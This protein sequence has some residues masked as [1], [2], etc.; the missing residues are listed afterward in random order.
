MIGSHKV[1]L[2]YATDPNGIIG[3]YNKDTG[4]IQPFHSKIDFKH[5]SDLTK[6][7]VCLMGNNTFKAIL[8]ANGEPLK[9]RT[10][11]VMTTKPRPIEK[12]RYWINK[13]YDNVIFINN[14]K[15]LEQVLF[16]MQTD[17]MVIGGEQIFNMFSILADEVYVTKW[18]NYAPNAELHLTFDMN[19]E[20]NGLVLNSD[21]YIQDTDMKTGNKLTGSIEH[22]R[23]YDK[24]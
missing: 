9:D 2:V 20:L 12:T 10:N 14:V 3:S 21:K 7:K 8:E 4:Y 6:G 23:Y 11:V 15:Q 16:L 22:W 17:L 19:F 1:T 18:N 5:F 13:G 24:L